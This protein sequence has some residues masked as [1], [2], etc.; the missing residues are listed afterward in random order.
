MG[1]MNSQYI[2]SLVSLI[3]SIVIWSG[4]FVASK[5]A[6]QCFSPLVLC[7]VRFSLAA[8]L[9]TV[10]R[11]LNHTHKPLDPS[12][13]RAVMLSALTGVTIYYAFENI[14]LSITSAGNA[15]VI[16]AVYPV[17]TILI[18]YAVFHDRIPSRQLTGILI[19]VFGIL[20]LNA[21]PLDKEGTKAVFGNLLLILNGFLWGIYN[22]L[23]NGI[24]K[25]TD[26]ASLTYYQCLYGALFFLPVLLVEPPR[27]LAPL[28]MPVVIALLF[29]TAGCSMAAYYFYNYG[30]RTL[31]VGTTL[32]V[33]N[34]MPVFG[35]VFSRIFLGEEIVPR[36]VIGAIAVIAGVMVSANARSADTL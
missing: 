29:L 30:L 7:A 14:G 9:M 31:S 27:L 22:Y 18:G 8:L 1:A 19:A 2:R 21:G 17:F 4:S 20:I 35:L 16:T 23:T 3:I 32:A 10:F 6:Y 26:T 34:L 28:T 11:C 15:S 12:D 5:I 24:T 33:M 25:N 36:T 13:R